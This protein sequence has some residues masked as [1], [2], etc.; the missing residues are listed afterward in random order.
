MNEK[1]KQSA[2]AACRVLLRP[3]V[4]MMLKH[5]VMHREFVE[6]TKEVYVAVTRQDHGLR[7][8]PTNVSRT[9]L[10]TGLDRKEITR[11]KNKLLEGEQDQAT[12]K[13]DRISRVLTGW[14]SDRDYLDAQGNPRELSLNTEDVPSWQS[15]IRTYGG[16][17]PAITILRELQRVDVV[18]LVGKSKDRVEVLNRNYFLNTKIDPQVLART[19]SVLADLGDTVTHN[20]YREDKQQSRFEA[21]AS[22]TNIPVTALR[23][24]R[25]FI[26]AESQK[27]LEG[28]D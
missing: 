27:F 19:G 26:Y 10:L 12:H 7:G 6:L 8:R 14:H 23:A 16:D 18:R 4:R 5:G 13:Q 3:V 28:V 25:K 21:R 17:V 1:L 2:L 22:N 15:L 20:L 24:Y 11:I 9:A